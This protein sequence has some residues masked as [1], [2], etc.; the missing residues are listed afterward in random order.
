MLHLSWEKNRFRQ[1]YFKNS[2]NYEAVGQW[3]TAYSLPIYSIL[4][5]SKMITSSLF[6]SQSSVIRI[7]SKSM[8]FPLVPEEDLYERNNQ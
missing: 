7:E 1:M 8:E 4:N 3:I 2:N 6:P 5:P